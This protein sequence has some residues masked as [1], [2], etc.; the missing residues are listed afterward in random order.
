MTTVFKKT[1]SVLAVSL[2]LMGAGTSIALAKTSTAADVTDS[3]SAQDNTN[4]SELQAAL[5]AGDPARVKTAAESMIVDRIQVL[6]GLIVD[7]ENFKHVSSSD[8]MAVFTGV[9]KNIS[10]LLDLHGKIDA[11]SGSTTVSSTLRDNATSITKD[12]RIG[13]LFHPQVKDILAADRIQTLYTLFTDLGKKLQSRIDTMTGISDTA[14]KGRAQAALDDMKQHMEN[15][16]GAATKAEADVAGLKPDQGD[17][18]VL[19][20]NNTQLA[21]AKTLL[22]GAVDD[23]VAARKDV[24]TI[25]SILKGKR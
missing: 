16:N 15:A 22:Q 3:I 23:L 1:A 14:A 8:K 20:T 17:R 9:Q 7:I 13:I 5:K 4:Q 19:A 24:D 25:I 11:E 2:V 18:T 10:A 12:Y 6:Q 21:E